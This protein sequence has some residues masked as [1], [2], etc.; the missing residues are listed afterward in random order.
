MREEQ[1]N[2]IGH[3]ALFFALLN[4]CAATALGCAVQHF[5]LSNQSTA[6]FSSN[7]A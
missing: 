5:S 2:V 4:N 7:P 3:S 1:P 6:S